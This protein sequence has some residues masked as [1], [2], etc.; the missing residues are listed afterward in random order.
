M[1]FSYIIVGFLVSAPVL[2]A[3]DVCNASAFV[4]GAYY[5]LGDSDPGA[6]AGAV[7]NDPTR[8][9]FIDKL[10]LSRFGSPHYSSN[11]PANGPFGDALSMQF[12]NPGGAGGPALPQ[13][14]GRTTSASMVDQGYALEAWVKP[15]ASALSASSDWLIAYNG[16]PSSNG[17]GLFLDGSSYVVRIGSAE[18]VI[19]PVDAANWHHIAY[20][21]SLGTSSYYYDGKLV[22]QSTT[23]ALPSTATSGLWIG[24][25]SIAAPEF[26][27]S[28]L[29]DEV[30]YQSYNP[31]VAGAFDPTDFLITPEPG[32][33]SLCCLAA[34]VFLLRRRRELQAS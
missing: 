6:V 19:G 30:R 29:I 32:T 22:R 8:D 18:H 33:L 14:Y 16:D 3:C 28:G 24:G 12:D 10:D 31:L 27:Y 17:F 26:L 25:D 7:G 21:Q 4:K 23:D 13:L 20:V 15:S 5:Q 9:S 2:L 1:R 11:V 34:G